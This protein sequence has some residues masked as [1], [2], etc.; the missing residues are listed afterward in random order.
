[1]HTC[2]PRCTIFPSGGFAAPVASAAATQASAA[3][4]AAEEPLPLRRRAYLPAN[5]GAPWSVECHV[6]AASVVPELRAAKHMVLFHMSSSTILHH[7]I[8]LCHGHAQVRISCACM[9][10]LDFYL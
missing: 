10:G 5:G 2:V 6:W 9:R 4:T 1:M 7:T 8:L 3:P